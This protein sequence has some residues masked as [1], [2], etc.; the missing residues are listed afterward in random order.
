[1]H[2]FDWPE[3]STDYKI[4]KCAKNSWK[5]TNIQQRFMP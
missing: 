2:S 5:N 3:I 1:M 4:I